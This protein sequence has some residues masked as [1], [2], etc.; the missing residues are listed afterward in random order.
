[1]GQALKVQDDELTWQLHRAAH[2]IINL[3]QVLGPKDSAVA[4]AAAT[5][6]SS[7]GQPRLA[8]LGSDDGVRVWLNG[9]LVHKNNARRATATDDDV[10]QLKLRQG[11]NR[12][13]IKVAND[14]GDWS[15]AF[16]LLSPES[17]TSRLFKAAAAGDAELVEKLVS[18]GVDVRVKSPFGLTAVQ[19]AKM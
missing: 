6:E 5:I 1:S 17:L 10:F 15:F 11:T 3:A 16:R 12:L 18:W 4:Y 13:L 19:V 9:E 14:R 8:G 2:D 7:D